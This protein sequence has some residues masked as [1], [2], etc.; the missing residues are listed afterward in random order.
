[1]A[2]FNNNSNS[3]NSN[4]S[5]YSSPFASEEL[6]AY[7]FQDQMPASSEADTQAPPTFTD[8]WSMGELPGPV[9]PSLADLSAAANHS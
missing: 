5:S 1:M 9:V 6:Y 7:P 8:L 4:A 2:H 3:N